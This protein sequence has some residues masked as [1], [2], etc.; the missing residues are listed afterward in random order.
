MRQLAH[1]QLIGD[2]TVHNYLIRAQELSTRLELAGE[3][4]SEILKN[5]MELNGLPKRYEHFVVQETFNPAGDFVEYR[6][7]LMNYKESRIHREFMDDVD[8]HVAMTSKKAKSNNKSSSKNNA[9]PKSSSGQLTYYCCGMKGHIKPDCYKRKRAECNFLKQ[10]GHPVQACIKKAP[11]TKLGSLASSLESNRASSE[12]TEQ[13]LVVHSRTTDHIIVKKTWFRSIRESDTTN[14]DG[15]NTKV[16]GI[17]E[18]EV[19]AKIFKENTEPLILK[20]A[21]YVPRYRTNLIS[22]SNTIDKG[23]KVVHEKKNS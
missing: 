15:G 13:G 7:R 19:L 23:R 12:T 4:L 17:G 6:T 1:L 21:L 3:H 8:L 2:E 5:A 11:G 22:V 16:L 14:P 20:K 18:V 9:Q 10:K